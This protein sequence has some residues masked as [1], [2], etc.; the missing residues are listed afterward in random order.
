[1]DFGGFIFLFKEGDHEDQTKKMNNHVILEFYDF[2]YKTNKKIIL[3]GL[4]HHQIL[5]ENEK[6]PTCARL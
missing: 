5:I 4:P 6:R 2:Q 3:C 1:V